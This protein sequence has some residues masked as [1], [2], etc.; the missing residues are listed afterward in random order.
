[1]HEI[2]D[3][4]KVGAVGLAGQRDAGIDRGIDKAISD[5]ATQHDGTGPAIPLGTTFLCS[6]GAFIETKIV[7]KRE[8]RCSSTQANH[9]AAAHELNMATHA[10]PA[11]FD[12]AKP[13]PNCYIPR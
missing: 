3:G 2:F 10:R 6:G 7:E 12:S 8:V 5:A 13:R 4:D 9:H 11:P 1:M